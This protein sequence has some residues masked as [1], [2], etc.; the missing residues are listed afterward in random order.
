M[1]DRL[2]L[3]QGENKFA[4]EIEPKTSSLVRGEE[5][6]NLLDLIVRFMINHVHPYHGMNPNPTSTDGVT[7]DKLLKEL[8]DAQDKLLNKN[9]RIN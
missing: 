4:D 5:L 3:P 6:I 2:N 7:V 9:I 1:A 8:L